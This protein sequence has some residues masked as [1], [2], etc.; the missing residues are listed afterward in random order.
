M[1]T[2]EAAFGDREHIHLGWGELQVAPGDHEPGE[3]LHPVEVANSRLLR[4]HFSAELIVSETA[5]ERP[6]APDLR[7]LPAR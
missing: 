5:R 1:A 3:A 6:L 4:R 7:P 2:V